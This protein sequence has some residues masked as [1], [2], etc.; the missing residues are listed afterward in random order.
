M[1]LEKTLESPLE[2]KEIKL[3]SPKGNQLWIFIGRTVA[4]APIIWPPDVK[5]WLTGKDSDAGKDWRREEKGRQRV[6]WSD[7]TADSMD[8]SLSKLRE[9]VIDREA[10]R[11]AVHGAA[12]SWIWLSN[13][14][15]LKAF[16]LQRRPPEAWLKE[17]EKLIKRLLGNRSKYRDCTHPNLISNPSLELLLWNS[18]PNL[19]T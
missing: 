18:L 8:M 17:P 12:K 19:P 5:N 15:E 3:V 10:C 13:W 16:L 7:G 14:T 4:E 2:C 6:R 1:V 9:L 11:A